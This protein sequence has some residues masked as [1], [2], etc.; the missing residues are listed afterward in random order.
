MGG[1]VQLPLD[2][3]GEVRTSGTSAKAGLGSDDLTAAGHIEFPTNW[4]DAAYRIVRSARRAG[5]WNSGQPF[6]PRFLGFN[7]VEVG[8]RVEYPPHRH[9][10]HELIA[11]E[12]GPYRCKVNGAPVQVDAG[13][14]LW[15]MP[16]DLHEVVC[17]RGQCHTVIHFRLEGAWF[18]DTGAGIFV[19]GIAAKDQVLSVASDRV[20]PLLEAMAREAQDA[21]AP[22]FCGEIQD[23]LMS[24]LFWSLLREISPGLLSPQFRKRTERDGLLRRVERELEAMTG[25]MPTVDKL[26]DRLGMSRSTLI[27]RCQEVLG[28]SPAQLVT[29]LRVERGAAMLL[30][31]DLPVKAVAYLLGFSNPFHFSRVF[32]RL[33]GASPSQYR[34]GLNE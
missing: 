12:C 24:Q 23:S 25:E 34:E 18:A 29:R 27:R 1:R 4:N 6:Q 7:R 2:S 3:E 32:K 8:G 33:T 15:V 30:E 20:Q 26:A 31:S 19:S 14:C 10:D 22:R 17:E 13:S 28:A 16:G 11:V 5:T 9:L 21:E